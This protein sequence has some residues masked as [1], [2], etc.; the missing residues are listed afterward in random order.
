METHRAGRSGAQ[1]RRRRKSAQADDPDAAADGARTRSRVEA[2]PDV[3]PEPSPSRRGSWCPSRPASLADD[4]LA[5]AG[6]KVLRFHLA[7]M[8]AREAGTRAGTD[9]EELHAMRV[10]TRRQRAAW[11]V[12]GDA[13]DPKRTARHRRRLR[14]VA[15]DLGA[16]RD[17]DV[18]I[19]SIEAYQGQQPE[20]EAA[21]LEP[22]VRSWRVRREAARAVL[23]R[24]LD[25]ERYGRWLDGY[26]AFVQAEGQGVHAV[27]PTEPHRVRD[28]MPSQGLERLPVRARVRA[29]HALGGRHHAPRPADRRQVAA[30]HARVRA[31]GARSRRGS[32][33][34]EGRR[35][36]GPPRLAARR[37]RRRGP[38]ARRSSS[39]TR[40]T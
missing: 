30:L 11:R 22:L 13:F 10:A 20:A 1:R 38:R 26:L 5:E 28:T 8:V 17:L 36:P 32:R 14:F 3:A 6:R 4:H 24:E 2:V 37:G 15:A 39:S 35:P 9:A 12:F 31:R 7:R 18:L 33:D 25:G 23:V 34:R 29:G 19:E 40:A 27:G 21:A 16:V